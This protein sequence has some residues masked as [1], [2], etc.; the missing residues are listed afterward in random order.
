VFTVHFLWRQIVRLLSLPFIHFFLAG[1]KYISVTMRT[2]QFLTLALVLP[3]LG[4]AAPQAN[5]AKAGGAATNK[6]ANSKSAD[7]SKA[8]A[9]NAAQL[10]SAVDAWQS[11]T[12]KVSNFLNKATTFTG[13]EFTKQATIALNAEKDELTHKKVIDD[14]LLSTNAD[15]KSANNVLVNKGT[16]QDVVDVLQDMVNQGPAN[17][18]A[19]ADTIKSNRWV[20]VLPNIDKYFAAA[21]EANQQ[22]IRPTGCANVQQAASTGASKAKAGNANAGKAKAANAGA[23]KA[24]A[25]KAKAGKA[26]N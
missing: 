26:N 12:G 9:P 18:H 13:N 23:G 15:V 14:A 22:A 25:S 2:V 21:G 16:F 7:A 19:Q 4:A 17:A 20:N 5:K 3:W 6:N 11:D 8:S 1:P 24:N 10:A